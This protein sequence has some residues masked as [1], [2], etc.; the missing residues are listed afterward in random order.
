MSVEQVRSFIGQ[1]LSIIGDVL[2]RGVVE[3]QGVV[4]GTVS[5]PNIHVH[6]GGHVRGA[7][8]ADRASVDGTV[9]GRVAVKNLISIGSSGRVSGDVRYG[10]LALAEG[11]DLSAD[12]H[13]VPPTLGGDFNLVVR[14]GQRVVVTTLDLTAYDP[15]SAPGDLVYSVSQPANGRIVRTNAP[16]T[17][18]DSFTQANLAAGHIAFVHDGGPAAAASFEIVVVDETGSGS[19]VPRRVEVTVV[20]W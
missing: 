6:Q 13:N 16:A 17:P 7:V 8:K 19:R 10:Q 11:G 2:G 15:D 14:R 12:V 5:A 18:I 20:D 4:Q 1:D 9:E 3:I